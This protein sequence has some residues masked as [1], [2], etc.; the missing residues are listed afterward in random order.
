MWEI[1]QLIKSHS[2]VS[3]GREDPTDPC[4]HAQ[5]LCTAAYLCPCGLDL[6]S[7]AFLATRRDSRARTSLQLHAVQHRRLLNLLEQ[8]KRRRREGFRQ[9]PPQPSYS[10]SS[11]ALRPEQF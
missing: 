5:G 7:L 8:G 11:Q 9:G 6:V 1:A 2:P 3:L 10:S 4:T